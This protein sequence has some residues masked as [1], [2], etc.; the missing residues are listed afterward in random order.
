MF[1]SLRL[2]FLLSALLQESDSGGGLPWWVW[3]LAFFVLLFLFWYFFIRDE[4][5]PEAPAAH[6]ETRTLN[7]T[8][9][10]EAVPEPEAAPEPEPE[11]EAAA[12]PDDLR[13]IEGIGP[14]VSGLLVSA[15]I[16]TFAQ[17]ANTDIARLQEILDAA[18][19]RYR[20][21]NPETWPEQ[22][23]LAAAGN[24]DGLQAL[25]DSLQAGRRAA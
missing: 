2:S 9:A 21:I 5:M 15:G 3:V 7:A 18:G 4:S 24:W 14:K 23:A 19:A 10:I 8:P 11:P 22:A 25:Q 1:S 20:I 6:H 13:K 16:T 12:A 17:L